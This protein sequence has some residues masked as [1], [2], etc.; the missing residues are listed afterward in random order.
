MFRETLEHM[1]GVMT[2]NQHHFPADA[3][4]QDV[5][6]ELIALYL[7]SRQNEHTKQDQRRLK[8]I[9]NK[10]CPISSNITKLS[11]QG[12]VRE[13]LT[14]ELKTMSDR[15]FRKYTTI[16]D[17]YSKMEAMPPKGKEQQRKWFETIQRRESILKNKQKVMKE[18]VNNLRQ[19]KERR[20][21]NLVKAREH[22]R[23]E[24][25]LATTIKWQNDYYLSP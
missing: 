21:A 14:N 23:V 8:K 17:L 16:L 20:Q 22:Q 12:V 2:H 15:D 10:L 25:S 18:H 7:N 24:T 13:K 6:E 9:E 3:P 19:T 11:K 4:N 1:E 5:Y